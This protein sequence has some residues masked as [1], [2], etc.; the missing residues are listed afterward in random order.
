VLAIL[1][2]EA[3]NLTSVE[4]AVKLFGADCRITKDP[5][6]VAGAEKV[7]F[8]GVGAA[9]ATMKN[10]I[11]LGLDK[12]LKDA[13]AA[14][15][16]TLGICIG[17]Q[18]VMEQSEEDESAC[19]GLIPGGVKRFSPDLKDA[20]GSPLKVPHMGWN[21]IRFNQHHPVLKDLPHGAEFYFVHSYYPVPA[22]EAN[23]LGVCDYGFDFCAAMAKGSLVALQFHAEKSGKPG[24]KIIE[25]FLNWDGKEGANAF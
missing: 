22:D 10:L 9:G 17:C 25:N 21:E 12:A 1:D 19:L 18:V 7:I 20:S 13:V 4:R 14:G 5:E 16:P 15:K 23:C 6:V 8:P 2:Y 24:L 11:R 3:G